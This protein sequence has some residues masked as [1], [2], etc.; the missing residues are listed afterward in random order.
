[1]SASRMAALVQVSYN[2]HS[3]CMTDQK[4]IEHWIQGCAVQRIM[5][6]DGLVLNLEEYNELVISAPIRLTLPASATAPVEVV[7]IDPNDPAMPERPLFDFSGATCTHV[8]WGDTGDLHLEF[9]D[10]HQIDVPS[11]DDITAWELYGKYHG[12]AACLPHG[13]VRV[14]R[15]DVPDDAS[16]D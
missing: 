2:S 12:Y 3:K 13:K 9:S 8:I 5:F 1:M 10:G 7:S 11:D 6:R 16:N 14:V 4:L 15:H